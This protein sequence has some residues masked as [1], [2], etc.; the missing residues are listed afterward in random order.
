MI[1]HYA[2]SRND[3]NALH[4]PNWVPGVGHICLGYSGQ[5]SADQLDALRQLSDFEGAVTVPDRPEQYLPNR[6]FA[7]L[8][9]GALA[10]GQSTYFAQSGDRS[11]FLTHLYVLDPQLAQAGGSHAEQ[12]FTLPVVDSDPNSLA[13]DSAQGR[14]LCEMPVADTLQQAGAA[15]VQPVP[16]P[17][18]LAECGLDEG[19]L[20]LLVQALADAVCLGGRQVMI[21][22][23]HTRP[24]Q[25]PT[26]LALVGWLLRL[27]PRH[28]R[29]Q[30][31]CALPYHPLASAEQ[32]QLVLV[33]RCNVWDGAEGVYY[34]ARQGGQWQ[35]LVRSRHYLCTGGYVMH[36]Q[37]ESA[38]ELYR[39][40]GAFAGAVQQL[41]QQLCAGT[42]TAA[43]LEEQYAELDALLT[44]SD[45]E[46][47]WQP[48]V[49][50]LLAYQHFGTEPYPEAEDRDWQLRRWLQLLPQLRLAPETEALFRERI[51]A[52][53]FAM[54]QQPGDD[55]FALLRDALQ[56]GQNDELCLSLAAQSFARLWPAG[57][58]EVLRRTEREFAELA[59][60]EV[61]VVDEVRRR[62]FCAGSREE[63]SS[64][65]AAGLCCDE[66]AAAGRCSQY[67]G[68]CLQ[69]AGDV[70]DYLARVRQLA[71]LLQRDPQA[72]KLLTD[73]FEQAAADW[74]GQGLLAGSCEDFALLCDV[75][76]REDDPTGLPLAQLL[77][78]AME[79]QQ[80][81]RLLQ[82]CEEGEPALLQ[83]CEEETVRLL[84][85]AFADRTG[86]CAAAFYRR[87]RAALL[88]LLRSGVKALP[89][90]RQ[91]AAAARLLALNAGAEER[92]LYEELC[93]AALG[94]NGMLPEWV[95]PTWLA[96]Q[97]AEESLQCSDG[98]AA[99]LLAA[100]ARQTAAAALTDA[101]RQRLTE[102][103]GE[104]GW[105]Q[106]LE[107]MDTL[108]RRGLP[109]WGESVCTVA[110]SRMAGG[111]LWQAA[112]VLLCRENGERF[113]AFVR[114]L[115]DR[116]RHADRVELLV[117][118]LH[119]EQLSTLDE[120]VHQQL[121][122]DLKEDCDSGRLPPE[123]KQ[124]ALRC[125]R[126]L[127][128][129][130]LQRQSSFGRAK[131]LTAKGRYLAEDLEQ[132]AQQK[133]KQKEKVW[134]FV[135]SLG[136][137]KKVDDTAAPTAP[138]SETAELEKA[139]AAEI[140]GWVPLSQQNNDERQL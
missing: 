76:D 97:Q 116:Q 80:A 4:G 117:Q 81:K 54:Q 66:Q 49:L 41:V 63:Q 1:G 102:S 96:Q 12:W 138:P 43:E 99:Q 135:S 108:Y 114:W 38:A 31:G 22:Y 126:R 85:A 21:A 51:L 62:L 28:L 67:I 123:H 53:L 71:P 57:A 3:G 120:T 104:D 98:Y 105:R 60:N 69:A 72:V 9:G 74:M 140:D 122:L 115:S 42:L 27:L 6:F 134:G 36:M 95:T 34:R 88:Q 68:C 30:V 52:D 48:E 86:S 45:S 125:S 94:K 39:S 136:G 112:C 32:F 100:L 119:S 13:P 128:D 24:E 55:W 15:P 20:C 35:D 47:L 23:D 73:A 25:Q 83:S 40:S 17:Q 139:G 133:E 26:L 113:A 16:L 75:V 59:V 2:Y 19:L 79:K 131:A 11:N 92:E 107:G 64:W 109:L 103:L 101:D 37:D 33:P 78:I 18:L 91:L 14:L 132:K 58:M 10:V 87:M 124:E 84:D 89:A 65:R 70:Q 118:L 5:W 29:N 90:D 130:Y 77:T 111:V 106:L 110:Q 137:R 50:D 8:P 93:A 56:T 44:G 129:A 46:L 127:W 121:M 61:P 82:L 7:R